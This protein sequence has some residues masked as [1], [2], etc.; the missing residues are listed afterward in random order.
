[1]TRRRKRVMKGG[2]SNLAN[3][4]FPMCSSQS[5]TPREEEG[6][7]GNQEEK[8]GSQKGREQSSQ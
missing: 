5:G 2:E 8:R 4:R 6:D 7:R 1:M 3:N